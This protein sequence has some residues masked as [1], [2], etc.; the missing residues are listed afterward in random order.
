[1]VY[2][3]ALVE[4]DK[5]IQ[6]MYRFKLEQ[7]GFE[8]HSAFNGEEGYELV[9][10]IRPDLILLDLK[11]PIMTGE[12]MLELVRKTDWGSEIKVIVL[13]NVSKDE[14]P[15]ILRV[16]HVDRYVVKVQHTPSQV[17]EIIDS[18]LEP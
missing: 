5:A 17:I 16:L 3:I 11:M 12:K 8:V 6:T 2:K 1:M 10:K 4:D 18:V 9:E 7:M 14:A 13:T 15:A